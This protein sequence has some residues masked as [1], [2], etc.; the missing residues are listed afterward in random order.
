MMETGKT[1]K[2]LYFSL[3]ATA[4]GIGGVVAGPEGLV[5]VLLPWSAATEQE[6]RAIIGR[7][8]PTATG[9]NPVSRE[10]ARQLAEYFAGYRETFDVPI[11]WEPLSPFQRRIYAIVAAIP[12]GEVRSYAA[13]SEAAGAPRAARGVGRAMARNPLP[14]IIPC[15][16]VV[17]ATGALTGYSAPG[18]VATKRQL[19]Q[20]EHVSLDRGGCVMLQK[21]RRGSEGLC[22][23]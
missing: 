1:G 14:I 17:A 22:T 21:K 2:L 16:R 9:E 3:Y 23:T 5:E 15:H 19:L 18:G 10:G 6:F 13:V 20:K 7:K 4:E 8:H 11:D 12:C